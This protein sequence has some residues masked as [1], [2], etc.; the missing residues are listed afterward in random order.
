[1]IQSLLFATDVI[2]C[3]PSLTPNMS[4][5]KRVVNFV[6]MVTLTLETSRTRWICCLCNSLWNVPVALCSPKY[7]SSLAMPCSKREGVR[8]RNATTPWQIQPWDISENRR[9]DSYPGYQLLWH[10][11]RLWRSLYTLAG[12]RGLRPFITTVSESQGWCVCCK[13]DFLI[14]PAISLIERG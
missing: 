14:T 1:M 12:L 6:F 3:D 10:I 9:N 13:W 7:I 11:A 5:E 2:S 8:N 4:S